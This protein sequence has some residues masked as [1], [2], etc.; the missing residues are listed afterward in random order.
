MT[1][2]TTK[3]HEDY[4][5]ALKCKYKWSLASDRARLSKTAQQQ[6]WDSKTTTN[7]FNNVCIRP[8]KPGKDI[9]S[10]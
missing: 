2:L 4:K 6:T 7:N 5:K 3:A 9:F 1:P 8:S 10:D